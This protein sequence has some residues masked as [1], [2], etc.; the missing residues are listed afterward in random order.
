MQRCRFLR[1][2]LKYELIRSEVVKTAMKKQV[3]VRCNI[4]YSRKAS[5]LWL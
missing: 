4:E 2:D 5:D 3:S 1:S